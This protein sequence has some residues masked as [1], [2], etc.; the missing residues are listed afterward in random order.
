MSQGREALEFAHKRDSS[1][2]ES[3]SLRELAE[4]FFLLGDGGTVNWETVVG[5]VT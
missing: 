2:K 1:K 4:K 3:L 5:L